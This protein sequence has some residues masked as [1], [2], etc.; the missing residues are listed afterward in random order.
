MKQLEDDIVAA[1]RLLTTPGLLALGAQAAEQMNLRP[2]P[3]E[4]LV[5]HAETEAQRQSSLDFVNPPA[6]IESIAVRG[7][8]GIV[9]ILSGDH[10]EDGTLSE[11]RIIF[12]D[13]AVMHRFLDAGLAAVR[14]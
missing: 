4:G 6:D 12:A 8:P 10:R 11:V 2:M 3:W 9:E 5:S 1:F 7:A 14:E 13:D